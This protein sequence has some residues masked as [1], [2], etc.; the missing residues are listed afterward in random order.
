M[1]SAL[2]TMRGETLVGEGVRLR[3]K[4]KD[5]K[6]SKGRLI[7]RV[8]GSKTSAWKVDFDDGTSRDDI[9]FGNEDMFAAFEAS[10]YGESVEVLCPGNIWYQGT[11]VTLIKGDN[12]FGIDFAD[13]DWVEDMETF[14]PFFR[15]TDAHKERLRQKQKKEHEKETHKTARDLRE[16]RE[17][18]QEQDLLK[19]R[20]MQ[21][22]QDLLE[23]R[24]MQHEQDLLKQRKMLQPEQSGITVANRPTRKASASLPANV[25]KEKKDSDTLKRKREKEEMFFIDRILG[26][27]KF[28]GVRHLKVRWTGYGA[29]EDTWEPVDRLKTDM[30]PKIVK[31]VIAEYEDCG[32]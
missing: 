9:C 7:E 10:A 4:F 8:V 31:N 11:L 30:G 17:V 26:D 22:E 19:Q 1:S 13:G 16:K 21:Q 29:D 27:K 14:S 12:L 28:N 25:Y 32:L 20:K 23:Q 18:Q 24:K 2:G 5:E 15:Y 3:I 6:W